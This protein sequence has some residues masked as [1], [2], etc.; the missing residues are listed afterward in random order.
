MVETTPYVLVVDDDEDILAALL[1]ALRDEGY[2]ADGARDA[3]AAWKLLET[4]AQPALILLDYM[5]PVLSGADLLER[6]KA[7][8]RFR[9]IPV[10]IS[11]AAGVAAVKLASIVEGVLE[12]PIEL[13]TL[14]AT[15]SRFLG[16]ARAY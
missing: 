6:M 15:V 2:R 3:M 4:N 7:D 14:Y 13:D 1:F 9:S 5:L 16:R 10:V 11:S 8:E 12:K